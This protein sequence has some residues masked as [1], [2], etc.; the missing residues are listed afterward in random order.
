MAVFAEENVYKKDSV[1]D[2]IRKSVRPRFLLNNIV[3]INQIDYSQCST[4][5][6]NFNCLKS[7]SS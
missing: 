3:S 2:F 5:A 1:P 4:A 7:I 6:Y